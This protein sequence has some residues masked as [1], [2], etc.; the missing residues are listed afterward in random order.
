M[1][2]LLTVIL[3]IVGAF[4]NDAPQ[5]FKDI[6]DLLN[7]HPANPANQPPLAPQVEANTQAAANALDNTKIP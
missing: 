3:S 5:F 6:Q 1:S 2:S 7:A 4:L